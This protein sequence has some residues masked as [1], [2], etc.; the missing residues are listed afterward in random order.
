VDP[1]FPARSVEERQSNF[2]RRPP[3]VSQ[4]G[5]FSRAGKQNAGDRVAVEGG[6]RRSDLVADQPI[7]WTKSVEQGCA[8]FLQAEWNDSRRAF[9]VKHP[10]R[11][12]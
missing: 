12:I 4:S 10:M 6:R 11:G 2:S 7:H 8:R 1:P 3:Q 5:R 9:P